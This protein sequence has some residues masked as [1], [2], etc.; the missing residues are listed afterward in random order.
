MHSFRQ[1]PRHE[2]GLTALLKLECL[3]KVLNLHHCRSKSRTSNSFWK[4]E[5]HSC[6]RC[7]TSQFFPGEPYFSWNK[8]CK[9]LRAFSK[10]GAVTFP[11]LC[12][13][14]SCTLRVRARGGNTGQREVVPFNMWDQI[15]RN[16]CGQTCRAPKETCSKFQS[17]PA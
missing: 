17:H 11:G 16:M 12:L 6:S 4:R 2:R 5:Q 14:T 13:C 8:G 3:S 1:L 7:V 10:P 15:H 9:T